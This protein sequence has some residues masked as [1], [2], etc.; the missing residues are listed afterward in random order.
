MDERV[1]SILKILE[2]D[3]T[4]SQ[5]EIAKKTNVGLGTANA[6]IKHCTKKGLIKVKK[7]NARSAQYLLTAD[8]MKEITKRS[9]N[10]IQKSYQAIVEIQDRVRCIA[11]EKIGQGKKIVLL[12]KQ[13]EIYQLAVNALNENNFGFQHYEDMEQMPEKNE[14]LFVIYWNPNYCAIDDLGVESMN[15]FSKK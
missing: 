8:G 15:L 7:L 12:S 13:D 2:D 9:I 5:R 6:L 1:I 10:Y 11:A 14:E 4:I 3:H